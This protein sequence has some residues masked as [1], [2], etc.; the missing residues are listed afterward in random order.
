MQF[1]FWHIAAHAFNIVEEM[2]V[3]QKISK[4]LKNL[5]NRRKS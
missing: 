4:I 5:E 2:F 3:N 1:F